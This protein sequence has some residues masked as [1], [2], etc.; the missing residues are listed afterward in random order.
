VRDPPG[1]GVSAIIPVRDGARYLGEAIASALS[2]TRPPI[3]V[4]V[5]D[6]GSTD[7]SGDLARGFGPAVRAIAQAPAGV[8]A[9]RNRGVAAAR[10]AWIAFLDS[11]DLWVPS[12]LERQ[13][14]VAAR[15]PALDAIFGQ[16]ETF[17]SPDVDA[18]A[19]P[20]LALP[21]G[22]QPGLLSGTMLVRRESFARVGPFDERLRAGEFVDWCARAREAGLR[23][24][25]SADVLLRRRVHDRNLTR[26]ATGAMADYVLAAKAALDRRR[27]RAEGGA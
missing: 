26:R 15:D 23:F 21:P 19:L 1:A 6:D 2:Q 22:P 7:G 8:A 9:A 14:D 18:A 12:K 16:F 5:V 4:I 11:D 20:R 25:V 27:A 10:A 3:E 13:A 17:V 24:H